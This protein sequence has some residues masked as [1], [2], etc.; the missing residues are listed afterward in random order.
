MSFLFPW[1]WVRFLSFFRGLKEISQK[2]SV[3]KGL[4]SYYWEHFLGDTVP[5]LV[6]KTQRL[7]SHIF[8]DPINKISLKKNTRNW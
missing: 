1:R 3:H 6:L 4:L 8:D 5:P 2:Y 7:K